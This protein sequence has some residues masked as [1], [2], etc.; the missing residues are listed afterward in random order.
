MLNHKLWLMQ[1]DLDWVRMRVGRCRCGGGVE[2]QMR[3]STHTI[4]PTTIPVAR[5][6]LY[7]LIFSVW[8]C[9]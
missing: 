6:P 4:P 2:P 8:T 5:S 1:D 9:V 3:D 7:R